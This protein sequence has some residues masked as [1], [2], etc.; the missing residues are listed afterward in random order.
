MNPDYLVWFL[1]AIDVMVAVGYTFQ[2]DFARA[3]HW[4]AAAV[5]TGSTIFIG[6]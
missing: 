3:V 4:F 6:R 1:A 2:E 5:L